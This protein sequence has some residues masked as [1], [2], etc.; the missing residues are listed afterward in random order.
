[1]TCG[2]LSS[3]PCSV[4]RIYNSR[5]LKRKKKKNVTIFAVLF[6]KIENWHKECAVII[7]AVNK[8]A[9]QNRG[10]N[11]YKF[12]VNEKRKIIK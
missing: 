12:N 4:V 7:F 9:A 5:F 8:G 11:Y 2:A 6:L 3:L 10:K 1:L